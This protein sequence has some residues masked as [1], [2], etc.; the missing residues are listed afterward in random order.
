MS[1]TM[2]N[3]EMYDLAGT[4]RLNGRKASSIVV[5]FDSFELDHT[6]AL[7]MALAG[8]LELD[9]PIT[10]TVTA[11]PAKRAWNEREDGVGVTYRITIEDIAA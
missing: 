5:A 7:H 1:N 3:A 2:F 9:H 4:P 11:K 8:K 10:L 6:D